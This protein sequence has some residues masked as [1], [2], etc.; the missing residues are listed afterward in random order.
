MPLAHLV[1]AYGLF[2]NPHWLLILVLGYLLYI[3]TYQLG[4]AIGLHRLFSHNAFESVKWFPYVS[5]VIS[6]LSFFPGPLEYAL[7]HRV[8]HAYSDTDRDPH[9]PLKGRLHAYLTWALTYKVN[10]KDFK[11]VFD[12]VRKYKWLPTY[13]KYEMYVPIIVYPIVF[14]VNPTAGYIMLLA[15]LLA[16]HA[17]LAVNGFGHRT[18]KLPGEKH[19][20]VNSLLLAHLVNPIFLHK[21]HHDSS[22]EYDYSTPEF[23]DRWAWVIKH[24]LMEKKDA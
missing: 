16:F 24:I 12:L 9:S 15:G 2:T 4:Q 5:A 18:Y 1:L 3:P 6:S 19:T 7:I 10:P 20:A 14:A 17:G 13:S 23:T 11:M 21:D 8:H 22:N